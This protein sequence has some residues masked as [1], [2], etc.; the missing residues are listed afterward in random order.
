MKILFSTPPAHYL[1]SYSFKYPHFPWLSLPVLAATVKERHQV[2]I[3]SHTHLRKKPHTLFEDIASFKPDVLAFAV[4]APVS[5]VS[6]IEHLPSIKKAFPRL[7]V[8]CGGQ[9]P[10]FEPKRLLDA[11]CDVICLGEADLTFPKLIDFLERGNSLANLEGIAYLEA[12]SIVVNDNRSYPTNLDEL[13]IP[14][15][16]LWPKTHRTIYKRGVGATIEIS[17]G[18]P[19]SCKF[20]VLPTFHRLY[21]EKSVARVLDELDVLKKLEVSEIMLADGTFAIDSEKTAQLANLIIARGYRFEFIAFMRADT[22][23]NNPALIELLSKAGL[24]MA[25]VGFESYGDESLKGMNKS[26]TFKI[27]VESAKIFKRYGIFVSGSHIYGYLHSSYREAMT[28]YKQGVRHCD[29][30]MAGIFTPLPGSPLFKELKERE[31]LITEEPKRI[32]YTEYIVKSGPNPTLF[33]MFSAIL[34]LRYYIS[35]KRWL[36]AI[37]GSELKRAVF[38]SEYRLLFWRSVYSLLRAL[39][40]KIL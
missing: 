26:A 29:H 6:V 34:Y 9:Y 18:C 16:E 24:K 12:E 1:Q 33:R 19:Y 25:I 14:A 39:G 27:N 28:T 10:T 40:I 20:C 4:P 36:G 5:A 21:R 3:V 8:I 11:G 7:K 30:Y 38:R 13:P 32:N 15:F 22:A 37:F 2:K 31:L 23:Y 35:P 17:R